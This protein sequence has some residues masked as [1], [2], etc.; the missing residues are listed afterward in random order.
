MP[1]YYARTV[2]PDLNG[3]QDDFAIDFPYLL[4]NHV[5]V[6]TR[7]GGDGPLVLVDDEEYTWT[8]SSV[9]ELN[10][11]P[12]DAT[13]EIRRETPLDNVLVSFSSGVIQSSSLNTLATQFLYIMQERADDLVGAGEA[14][15]RG[16]DGTVFAEL[17]G[18]D[19]RADR[20][21]GFD[22]DG[23]VVTYAVDTFRGDPGGNVMSVGPFTSIAGLTIPVGT[24]LIQTASWDGTDRD[25]GALYVYDPDATDETS[26]ST[27]SA[28]GRPFRI[29]L[30][31]PL[32][33]EKFGGKGDCV[34]FAGTDNLPILLEAQ[35]CVAYGPEASNMV[36]GPTIHFR[37]APYFFSDEVNLKVI[38]QI[39]GVGSGMRNF[40]GGTRFYYPEDTTGIIV[41]RTNTYSDGVVANNGAADGSVIRGIQFISEGGTDRTK[42]GVWMRARCR[43]EDCSFGSLNQGRFPGNAIN[44]VANSGGGPTT[45]GNANHWEVINCYCEDTGLHGLFLSG[46]DVNAGYC[47]GFEVGRCGATGIHDT[48]GLG[49]NTF[50]AFDIAGWGHN[51]EGRV[52]RTGRNYLLISGTALIG[53]AT[54]PGTN[55][56][57]W[58]DVGDTSITTYPAW[59]SLGDYVVELP[60]FAFGNS[61]R[62]T[63][64]GNYTEGGTCHIQPPS[65]F[66]GGQAGF[67]R[68]SAGLY[69]PLI[70]V[71]NGLFCPTGIGGYQGFY[72]GGP[73]YAQMGD[74][75]YTTIGGPDP[76]G[77]AYGSLVMEHRRR[78]DAAVSWCWKWDVDDQV[79]QYGSAKM[80]FRVTGPNTARTFG[81]T[82]VVPYIFV[83]PQLGI[84]DPANSNNSR[85]MNVCA[86]LPASG[87]IAKGERYWMNNAGASGFA[88][89]Y[90]TTAGVLGSTA[91]TKTANPIS[92]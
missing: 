3:S 11:P 68:N 85:I 88:E 52:S 13:L 12:D 91:V 57:V 50:L 28:N 36:I 16:P 29:L 74:Y 60:A 20:I 71:H 66:L 5:K 4:Q 32:F 62:S 30:T 26:W 56:N 80:S 47:L 77:I 76:S 25:S 27:T 67:T 84:S 10:T 14:Y 49:G 83:A 89:T 15:V 35:E 24:D 70:G 1:D 21:L 43:L 65:V 46:S 22:A 75:A 58:M 63:F 41:N 45:I 82:S 69:V 38:I 39:E 2:F 6:Y 81:R 7:E 59:V 61:T 18:A 40:A 33:I 90:C 92:A 44:I 78:K 17:D 72:S 42:H 53:G 55:E 51:V 64:A 48:S 79:Y 34:A 54:E 8:S 87:E 19:G 9:I 31:Q 86:T 37:A 23:D 73:G